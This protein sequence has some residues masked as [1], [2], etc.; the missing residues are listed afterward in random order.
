MM[1]KAFTMIELVFVIVII[2]ILS[3]IAIPKFQHL[4]DIAYVSKGKNTLAIVR[5]AIANERQKQI[6]RGDANILHIYNAPKRVFTRFGDVNGSRILDHDLEDCTQTGCWHV[7]NENYIFYL[8]S[9]KTCTYTMDHS[10]FVD[11]TH[12]GCL[13][14]Q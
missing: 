2:A 6:L 13:E 1:K 4:S 3:S 14:L 5:S 10:H 8:N 9:S 12:G 7:V 11:K